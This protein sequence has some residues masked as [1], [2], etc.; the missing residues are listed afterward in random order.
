MRRLQNDGFRGSL[1]WNR[2]NPPGPWP[3]RALWIEFIP[4]DF[5]VVD[6]RLSAIDEIAIREPVLKT[7]RP[8]S[9][10]IEIMRFGDRDRSGSERA[11]RRA[12]F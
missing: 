2:H 11:Q 8:D 10:R 5:L 6:R 3:G 9:R 12:L 1:H 4:T 7:P